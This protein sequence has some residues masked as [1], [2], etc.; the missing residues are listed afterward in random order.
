MRLPRYVILMGNRNAGKDVVC[1]YLSNK[2][3]YT[4]RGFSDPLYEI[5]AKLDPLIA[6][7]KALNNK[8]ARRYNDLVAEFGIDYTKRN[9]REVRKFL[10]LLGTE[11]A[12]EL[13]GD[14]CWVDV[15]HQRSRNDHWTCIRD[16]RFSSEVD[17]ARA[18][19]SLLIHVTSPKETPA[20]EHVSEHSIDYSK[21]SDYHLH[22]D[23]DLESLYGKMENILD[24]WA[25]HPPTSR[26]IAHD[27]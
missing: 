27:I 17:W 10:Q 23:S 22:N 6:T 16:A 20:G 4:K 1:D 3:C 11:G 18:E 25:A 5:L 13:F 9:F 7:D 14:R 19:D 26:G 8:A 2:Y 15:M 12:R 21:E 24:Q